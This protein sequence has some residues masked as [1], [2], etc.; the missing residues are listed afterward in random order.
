MST[1]RARFDG[2][3]FVPVDPVQLPTDRL[4]ELEVRDAEE[5]PRGSAQMLRQAMR[6]A[7]HVPPEDVEALEQAIAAGRAA[8]RPGGVFDDLADGEEP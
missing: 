8:E 6:Q 2:K 5:L 1:I 3:V 4:V 7:P